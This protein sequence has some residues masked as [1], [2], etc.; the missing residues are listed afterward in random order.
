MKY[1]KYLIVTL[2][3]FRRHFDFKQFYKNRD[4]FVSD[5]HPDKV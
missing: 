1:G 5:M 2:P 3:D 4:Q